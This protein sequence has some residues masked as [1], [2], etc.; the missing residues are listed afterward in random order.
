[1][2]GRTPARVV[3][4]HCNSCLG[5]KNHD[6]VHEERSDWTEEVDDQPGISISGG[7]IWTLH[8][9]RGCDDVRMKHAHWFSEDMDVDGNPNVAEEWFPPSITRQ[10]PK[11]LRSFFPFNA[12]LG[13]L[14]GLTLEIYGALAIGAHR[15]AAMGIRALVERLMT[16]VVGDRGN[17]KATVRAFFDAGY[18]AP[19]QQ[20][21]FENTLIEAGHAAMH[22]DFAPSAED[23]NTLLDIVEGVLDAVYYQ[24][25]LADAVRKSIPRRGAE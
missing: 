21:M 14:S 24:P 6:V 19:F 1:M 15:V 12:K 5:W 17:F 11:W 20:A 22:R 7:H 18:V 10:K 9:C 8:R 16:D 2:T 13:D 25:M 23:V 4:E 3:K